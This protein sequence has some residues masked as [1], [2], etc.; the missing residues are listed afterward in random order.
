MEDARHVEAWKHYQK[1]EKENV[2]IGWWSQGKS[3]SFFNIRLVGSVVS[4]SGVSVSVCVF[5]CVCWGLPSC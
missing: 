2:E 1:A 3:D 5:S 4:H